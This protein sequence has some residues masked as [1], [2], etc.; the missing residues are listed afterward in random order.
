MHFK[1]AWL[2]LTKNKTALLVSLSGVA[3]ICIAIFFHLGFKDALYDSATALN[4][5]L[6]CQLVLINPL[7]QNV[8]DT[9][10]I[11][12]AR[13]YE[14]RGIN[15]VE[16]VSY[17][18]VFTAIWKN[19]QNGQKRQ[20][21]VI[22][23]DPNTRPL[24]LA[25][26]ENRWTKLKLLNN[27]LYDEYSREL[28]GPV[29][30]Q[31]SHHESVT[32]EV[33]NHQI[34]VAGLFAMYP[35]FALD[36]AILTSNATFSLLSPNY[37]PDQISIGLVNVRK[38]VDPERMRELLQ[39][40]FGKDILVVTRAEF[41]DLEKKYW[42]VTTPIGFQY[43]LG[44]M[45]IIVVGMVIV[46][47]ILFTDIN[48]HL[49]QYATLKAIGFTQGFL[50]K[51]VIKEALLLGLLGFVPAF[52]LSYALFFYSCQITKLPVSMNE[53]RCLVVLVVDLVM[54]IASAVIATRKLNDA[55]PAEIF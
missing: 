5:S 47:Q 54:C 17:L 55:D 30:E 24:K 45:V 26:D 13:L 42:E 10:A 38:D 43:G 23:C 50:T 34:A 36:G 32:A 19:P 53:T 28:F 6:N 18:N 31:I 21:S 44:L 2:K 27:V 14:C 41:A 37:S 25:I 3:F 33:N 7:Y 46:Y 9:K 52:L 29:V 11:P 4:D 8:I 35:S 12:R 40:R 15:G 16:G 20:I 22:G 1:L 49:P 51:L 48:H 39:K